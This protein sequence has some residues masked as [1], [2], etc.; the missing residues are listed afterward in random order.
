MTVA[1]NTLSNLKAVDTSSGKKL[2]FLEAKRAWYWYDPDGTGTPDDENVILPNTNSGRWYKTEPKLTNNGLIYSSHNGTQTINAAANRAYIVR[3]TDGIVNINLP[4]SPIVGDSVLVSHNSSGLSNV[5]R[6]N[7]NGNPIRTN[8]TSN[9]IEIFLPYTETIFTYCDATVGWTYRTS[10]S[11]RLQATYT[12]TF[13][14]SSNGDTNGFLHWLGTNEG[15]ASF[16]NPVSANGAVGPKI[17]V[18]SGSGLDVSAL[19]DRTTASA[20]LDDNTVVNIGRAGLAY[21]FI[22]NRNNPAREFRLTSLLLRNTTTATNA[23]RNFIIEGLK[24]TD[25]PISDI[26]TS[27]PD[28]IIRLHAAR[29]TVLGEFINNTNMAATASSYGL[30]SIN[31]TDYYS[32]FRLRPAGFDASGSTVVQFSIGE[33]E[34]YGEVRS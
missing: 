13:T 4:S 9:G 21:F 20:A 34:M 33:V 31:D 23:L 32:A 26:A 25:I 11:V 16:I 5:T 15:S 19:T 8:T 24:S 18:Y 10:Q 7:R 12:Q 2:R 30:Y 3:S 17:F 6:V 1:V 29:W 14:F 27:R 22:I 28:G